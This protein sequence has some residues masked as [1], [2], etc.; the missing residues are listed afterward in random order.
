MSRYLAVANSYS[1]ADPDSPLHV[2]KPLADGSL[3]VSS[4]PGTASPLGF[5]RIGPGIAVSTALTVPAGATFA[6]IIC[7][8]QPVRWRDDGV[9]PTASIG[10]PLGQDASLTYSGSLSAIRF[11]EQTPQATLSISYYA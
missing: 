3:K 4:A 8:T 7:E 2:L 6:E 11:I 1:I 10:M 9:A 5:Q